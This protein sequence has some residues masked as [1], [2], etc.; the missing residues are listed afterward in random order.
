MSLDLTRQFLGDSTIGFFGAGHLGRAIAEG[1]LDVGLPRRCLAI[2]HRK[3][4]ETE[5]ELAAAGL[6]DLVADSE[7]VIRQSRILFYLVRPQDRLAIRDYSLRDDS[8]FVSFM[9]GIPLQNLPVRISDAQRV[10]VMTSAP[11]TVRQ[12]NGVAALYPIDIPVI[13]EIL[14]SLGLWIVALRQESDIHA[15][16]ALG[17]CLPS[18]LTYCDSLGYKVDDSELLETARKVALPDYYPMLQWAQRVRPKSLPAAEREHYLTQAA[19]PGGVTEAILTALRNGM[20][21]PDALVRGIE[22][23]QALAAM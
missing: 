23:S 14:E 6:S 13:Y 17:T 10:R 21:L 12:R 11:D 5:R 2:C 3:S 22:R 16:T 15:F 1:L 20:S 9:A 19:T 7:K 18:V 4:Q 8:L